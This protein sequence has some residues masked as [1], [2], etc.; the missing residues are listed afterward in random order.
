[1]RMASHWTYATW[2]TLLRIYTG[3]FW[4]AHGIPKFLDS[5]KFMPPGG[6]M[7]KVVANAVSSQ[8]GPYHD[9]LAGTVVPHIGLFAELV[10][11]GEVLTGCAL[12]LGV[13]T[14]FGGLVGCFLA[15]NYALA[16]GDFSDWTSIGSMDAVA[17]VLSF[18]MLAVPAGR[19][20]GVDALMGRPA[21][22]P[23]PAAQ[24]V[25]PEFIDEPPRPAP[26]PPPAS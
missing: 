24:R 22:V 6:F 13:F 23:A 26:P 14:R 11:L 5:D 15:L 4:L 8:T 17:F 21:R 7:P 16:N 20:L 9:F 18:L 12:L 10:R 25:V 1:M 19:V 2:F 3:V